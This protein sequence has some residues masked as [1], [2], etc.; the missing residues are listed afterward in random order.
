MQ[1]NSIQPRKFNEANDVFSRL[2]YEYANHGY[3]F[4]KS[5]SV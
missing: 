3:G 1:L 5:I 2:V 4:L